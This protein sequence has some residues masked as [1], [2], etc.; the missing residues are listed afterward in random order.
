LRATVP[1]TTEGQ[2]LDVV[3]EGLS[4]RVIEELH[5]QVGLYQFTHA[6]I[7]ETLADE[8]TLTR[9]VR[10]HAR[11]AE[12]MEELYGDSRDEHA[13][14]LAKHFEQAQTVLGPERV[15]HY[16]RVAGE[17]ALAALGYDEAARYFES[18]LEA[19][20]SEGQPDQIAMLHRDAAIAHSALGNVEAA[21]DHIAAAFTYFVETHQYELAATVARISFVSGLGQAKMTRYIRQSL[22]LLDKSS[23]QRPW[24]M[25]KLGRSMSMFEDGYNAA[26]PILEEAL[27]VA[28]AREDRALEMQILADLTIA[29]QWNLDD[30]LILQASEEMVALGEYVDDP[31]SLSQAY[32]QIAYKHSITGDRVAA[33]RSIEAVIEAATRAGDRHRLVTN[34]WTAAGINLVFGNWEE[35]ALLS[36]TAL[37]SIPGVPRVI[38]LLMFSNAL[39]GEYTEL[40]ANKKLLIET[41]E[42]EWGTEWIF[43]LVAVY[44]GR[45][46]DQ[47]FWLNLDVRNQK[48]PHHNRFTSAGDLLKDA[49]T[50]ALSRDIERSRELLPGLLELPLD[51]SL[52]LNWPDVGATA[53]MLSKVCGQLDNAVEYLDGSLSFCREKRQLPAIAMNCEVLA[54]VL[55]ER[56]APGDHLRAAELQDEAIA[57]ATELGMQPLLERVLAQREILKA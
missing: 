10:V 54:E 50:A 24:L 38:G 22:E 30:E 14:E 32:R 20:G 37:A 26:K 35:V 25:S 23:E 45:K 34:I 48:Q 17:N 3:D 53:G 57:I 33:I 47:E 12:A 44:T 55:L 40:A 16:S 4:A 5:E 46:S 2:L 1:D 42:V 39:T 51:Y 9:R 7:E 6:L 8:L 19:F 18:A 27:V 28:R 56:D 36:A 21:L 29:A 11:V 43:L 52:F 13:E 31:L 15:A 41:T 49:L